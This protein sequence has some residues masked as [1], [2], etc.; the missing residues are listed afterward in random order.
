MGIVAL[1]IGVIV[2]AWVITPR[3]PTYAEKASRCEAIM[4]SREVN[5]LNQDERAFCKGVFEHSIAAS[6][7]RAG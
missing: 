2:A 3:A 1:I 4:A 6:G 5:R 7:A